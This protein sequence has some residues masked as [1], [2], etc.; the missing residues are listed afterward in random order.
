MSSSFCLQYSYG[1]WKLWSSSLNAIENS[2]EEVFSPQMHTTEMLRPW[3]D[4]AE[5]LTFTLSLWWRMHFLSISSAGDGN[6][7]FD[8]R[9]RMGICLGMVVSEF[10]V[11]LQ[12][13]YL[14]MSVCCELVP[15]FNSWLFYVLLAPLCTDLF[16]AILSSPLMSKPCGLQIIHIM[17]SICTH[18][19][20]H[21]HATRLSTH[22]KSAALIQQ[23]TRLTGR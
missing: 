23:I 18:A 15:A 6:G 8:D 12:M 3:V 7:W 14:Y 11:R 10:A 1:L 19:N 22:T 4:A 21:T 16:S 13:W 5:Q 17:V 9:G 2:F 20:K